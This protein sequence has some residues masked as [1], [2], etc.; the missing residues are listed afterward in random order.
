M[1]MNRIRFLL[2]CILCSV[3]SFLAQASEVTLVRNGKAVSA[4]VLEKK[5]TRSAWMAAYELQHVIHLITGVK[6]PVTHKA[7][8]GVLPIYLGV[9]KGAKFTGEQYEVRVCKD[10][11]RLGGNDT[12]DY[13]KVDYANER[14]FPG[15]GYN[16]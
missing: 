9:E 16:W 3:F 8:A 4:I 5:P 12:A 13:T 2:I 6:L 7:P 11:I 14:T 10:H 15:T 1:L